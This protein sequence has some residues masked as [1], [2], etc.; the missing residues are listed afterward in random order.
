MDDRGR[1][2]SVPVRMDLKADRDLGTEAEDSTERAQLLG[3]SVAL[4]SQDLCCPW[5][6]EPPRNQG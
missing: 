1:C 6:L 5:G 2:L 4:I 3:H